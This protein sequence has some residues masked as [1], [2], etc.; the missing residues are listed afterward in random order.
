MHE[1]SAADAGDGQEAVV[2]AAAQ[3]VPHDEERVRARKHR[4]ERGDDREGEDLRIK[5]RGKPETGSSPS[6]G[7]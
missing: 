7:H 6:C 3:R 5:H 2:A 1:E 4:H